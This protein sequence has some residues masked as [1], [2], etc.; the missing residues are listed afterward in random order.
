L[1]LTVATL[2]LF[3]AWCV[4]CGIRC[5]IEDEEAKPEEKYQ[6]KPLEVNQDKSSIPMNEGEKKELLVG[7]AVAFEK[8]TMPP[9]DDYDY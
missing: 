6:E 9:M 1:A 5:T 2:L 4:C 3:Y 8:I 7:V